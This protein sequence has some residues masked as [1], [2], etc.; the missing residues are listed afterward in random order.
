[1]RKAFAILFLLTAL[2]AIASHGLL[3]LQP[4][5][6]HPLFHFGLF[7]F[8]LS[9]VATAVY[10]FRPRAA[11]DSAMVCPS[12]HHPAGLA[13]ATLGQ[14]HPS[15]LALLLGGIILT[16]LIHQSQSRLF[17]CAACSAESGRR[18]FGAWLSIGWCIT[19]LLLAVAEAISE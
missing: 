2:A 14:P 19:I 6:F 18:T 10:L 1:M 16:I 17:R 5:V 11:W 8:E 3:L 15:I 9:S 4:V 13:P 12:C 7:C